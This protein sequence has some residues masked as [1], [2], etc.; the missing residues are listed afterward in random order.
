MQEEKAYRLYIADSLFYNG[1]QQT[2]TIRYCDI[3]DKSKPD[4]RTGD[5]IALEIIQKHGLKV[6]Q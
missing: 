5:E 3:I 4:S 1:K 6:K 2:L